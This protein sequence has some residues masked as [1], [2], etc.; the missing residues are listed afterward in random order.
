MAAV[1]F[2]VSAC[3]PP[4]PFPHE[5]VVE[6]AGESIVR[7]SVRRSDGTAGLATGFYLD[8]RGTVAT[9]A[10]VVQ[11]AAGRL[12]AAL[13]VVTTPGADHLQYRVWRHVPA[14]RMAILAPVPGTD[15]TSV[16]VKLAASFKKGEPVMAVGWPRSELGDPTG[17]ATRG[18]V[19]GDAGAGL[20]VLDMRTAPGA[21]GAPVFNRNVQVVA[22]LDQV[23]VEDD[24]FAYA[25]ALAGLA[26]ETPGR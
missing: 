22:F 8:A 20:L 4:S 3:G 25:V 24:A 23:G 1:V 18:I 7:I 10:H 13:I 26:V 6:A 21:S 14:H 16:P 11:N 19:A 15:A 5:S 17:L 12:D 2:A 9:A